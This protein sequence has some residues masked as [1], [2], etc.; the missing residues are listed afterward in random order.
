MIRFIIEATDPEA[1]EMA[2]HL[3]NRIYL[4]SG[5]HELKEEIRGLREEQRRFASAILRKE[6]ELMATGQQLLDAV[7]AEKTE[8]DSIGVFIQGL[9]DQLAA[10]GVAQA[11]IDAAF[12]GV[13]ANTAA[14]AVFTN[15]PTPVPSNVPSP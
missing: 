6:V 11:A 3:A 12:A 8:V 9:K 2:S 15:T 14:L 7:T 1:T 13:T 4:I 5:F 10:N